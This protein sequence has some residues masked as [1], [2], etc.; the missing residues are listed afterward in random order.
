MKN[1][2]ALVLEGG[3][4]RGIFTAGVVDCFLDNDIH[5]DYVCGVSAGSGNA[6]SFIGGTR[7]FF[8]N[9][10]LQEKKKDAFFGVQQMVESHKIVNLDRIFDDYTE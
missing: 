3:G 9:C 4:L 10:V 6:M 5:F 1:K 7:E 2:L 8:K